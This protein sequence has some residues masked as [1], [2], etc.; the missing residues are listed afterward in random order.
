MTSFNSVYRIQLDSVADTKATLNINF[1]LSKIYINVI[2]NNDIN[3]SSILT[4]LKD[5]S[6]IFISD[7]Y[8]PSNNILLSVSPHIELI[9]NV[10]V[11]N[12]TIINQTGTFVQDND[13]VMLFIT[14][15]A[16]LNSLSN[17]NIINPVQNDFLKYNENDEWSNYSLVNTGTVSLPSV[18][19][20]NKN[21]IN[22][23]YIMTTNEKSDLILKNIN[24]WY[25]IILTSNFKSSAVNS[26]RGFMCPSH[27]VIK[28]MDEHQKY[29]LSIFNISCSL[30]SNDTLEFAI[31]IN[32][33]IQEPTTFKKYMNMNKNDFIGSS[34]MLSFNF[35]DEA[36]VF[37]RNL[38]TANKILTF[39]SYKFILRV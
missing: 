39:Y 19:N 18:I 33:M 29:I 4:S 25:P 5:K 20:T 35:N 7:T 6:K 26:S 37:V 11:Y 2:D 30:N 27:G 14:P 13:S 23:M 32:D 17:V 36:C 16:E 31:G 24:E 21:Y 12:F 9:D 22:E 8:S 28:S 15:A 3:Y 34:D 10:I 1:T 38:T